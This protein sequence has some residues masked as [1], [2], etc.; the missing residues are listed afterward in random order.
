MT[1]SQDPIRTAVQQALGPYLG[2]G[3]RVCIGFSGGMDS[4]VLLHALAQVRVN[5]PI[6]LLAVHV[7]HGISPHADDWAAFCQ[8]VCAALNV[9]CTVARVT[10][11]HASGKGVECVAREARYEAFAAAP[12]DIL[13]LAHH[14]NDRAETFLLNLFRGASINGLAGVPDARRLGKKYVLRPFINLPRA[15]LHSWA[16]NRRLRWV[17]D[18][19]N[20][21][22]IFRRNFVR[23]RV[24]PVIEEAFP[25]AVGVL[26]RTSA[27]MAEQAGLLDRLAEQD[28]ATCRDSA[29][30]LSV[31]RLQK[32][33]EPVVRNI[34]RRALQRSGIQIPA[35]RR[36]EAF[37]T[38]LMTV[39]ADTECFVRMGAAGVHLWRDRVWVDQAMEQ[40]CPEPYMVQ[41][42]SENWPDGLLT[43]HRAFPEAT[44]LSELSVA[45][46]GQG[47]R[48]QPQGRCRD[49]V[50]ELL[51][52]QGVPPWVRPRLPAL[53]LD[54]A[55]VWVAMLGWHD[56]NA[57]P[58]VGSGHEVTWNPRPG[59][60]L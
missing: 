58:H 37:V 13:C 34:L 40:V 51:R 18:D 60:C 31:A 23:H 32:L 6:E 2:A 12:G 19:S 47:Q 35:A 28:A 55:L 49:R 15:T 38:Q 9:A 16:I 24:L 3:A 1:T 52:A 29:G 48:F 26:A 50:S 59:I 10:V 5:T 21:N 11:A 45:P 46:V 20:Q 41:A 30:L 39:T 54:G 25:G 33:P 17:E 36:L 53:W 7:H 27:H 4:L 42:G 8:S 44:E 57:M 56:A 22:L 14:Q 43:I